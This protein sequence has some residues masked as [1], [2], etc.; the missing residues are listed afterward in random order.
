[1]AVFRMPAILRHLDNLTHSLFG[2]TIARTPLG[3]AGRG[4]TAALLLASNAPDVDIV[5][6]A[7]GAVKYLEWHRGPTHGP[8]GVVGLAVVT[9][10][11]VWAGRRWY[12]RKYGSTGNDIHPPGE[13]SDNASFAMLVAVSLIGIVLHIL[14]DLPTVYGTRPFS[15]FSWRWYAV[16]WMPIV[17]IYLLAALAIGLLGKPTPSQARAKATF[18]LLVMA[19]NYG[20][21]AASHHQALVVAPRLFGPTLPQPCDGPRPDPALL[22]SWPAPTPAMRAD[23]RR[24]L[25]EMAA[26]PS[27]TSPFKWRIIARTSNAY[28]MH[29][30]DLLDER[31]RDP[32]N[33]DNGDVPWRLTLRY[34]DIWTPTV[35]T[36]AA[37]DVGQVFLGFSRFPAARSAID[38]DGVTTVRW[39]DVRFAGGPLAMDQGGGRSSMFTA[40]VRVGT[41]GAIL[42]QFLGNR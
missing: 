1:M 5:A 31:F 41:T 14:M 6:T 35:Q 15:P 29:D 37:T 8:F 19:T 26:M 12:D 20:L 3:R 36:A 10:A 27:F 13:H 30:I 39:T 16:D 22:E 17:D 24:C 40:T 21:R 4:T 18:V 9:A 2:A 28:E 23:G 11:L 38:K 32:D 34:P 33:E 42:A 7:G 25:V